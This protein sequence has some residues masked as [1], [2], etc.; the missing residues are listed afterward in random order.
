MR[1][2]LFPIVCALAVSISAADAT[3][4][5]LIK[6]LPHFLDR[7]GRHALSP[8]LYDRDA[9]QARLR[10]HPELRSGIRFDVQWRARTGR[11]TPLTL[12]LE[13][14]GSARGDLPTQVTLE[15][16]VQVDR[17]GAGGGWARLHLTGE[18]YRRFG[19]L[20]AWRATLWDGETQVAEQRSFLW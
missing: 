10:E 6:V 7:E 15:T 19:E 16:R 4:A 8:S 2:F 1:R 12:R 9:Y 13:L 5:R 17:S 14:R 3:S 11:P 18:D 20:T